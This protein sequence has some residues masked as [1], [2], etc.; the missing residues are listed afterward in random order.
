MPKPQHV[1]GIFR[2]IP[3]LFNKFDAVDITLSTLADE[4]LSLSFQV[5]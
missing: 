5:S 1:H 2:V 3:E 4:A